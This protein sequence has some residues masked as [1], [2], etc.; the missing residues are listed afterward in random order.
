MCVLIYSLAKKPVTAPPQTST[1]RARQASDSMDIDA[2]GKTSSFNS[3]SSRLNTKS[4]KLNT[5][6]KSVRIKNDPD[7]LAPFAIDNPAGNDHVAQSAKVKVEVP[8][9]IY[10]E[11]QEE[12]NRPAPR[13]D[14]ELINLVTD[15]EDDNS[16]AVYSSRNKGKGRGLSSKGGLKPVRLQREEHKE[17]VTLVN[18]E[19]AATT[20]T[21]DANEPAD[22]QPYV[23][24]DD[25]EDDQ[26]EFS[27][28]SEKWSGVWQDDDIEVKHDP[29]T[30]DAMDVDV[31]ADPTTLT[32]SSQVSIGQVNDG[33][34]PAASASVDKEKTKRRRRPNNK[35]PVLQTEEDRA[36]YARHL[37]DLR[38]LAEELGGVQINSINENDS[39]TIDLDELTA[40]QRPVKDLE[41]RLYLF[42]LPPALPTLVNKIKKEEATDGGPDLMEVEAGPSSANEAIDLT[43]ADPEEA[44]PVETPHGTF[45]VPPEVVTEEGFVG[46]LI[47][48]KSGKVQMDWGG[49]LLELGRGVQSDYLTTTMIF[50][51]VGD[52]GPSNASAKPIGT[53]TGMGK[54]MGNFVLKPDFEA[55]GLM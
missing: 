37:E 40:E 23:S 50:E 21:D 17:R 16:D 20:L 32:K 38:I 10:P 35:Q 14:I 8:D 9:P 41:G 19:P 1:T 48:R 55:M 18:T 54:V 43:K 15:D 7:T 25:E 4:T 49:V 29:G 2:Q 45:H 31:I 12:G 13:V 34:D 3:G 33:R 22:Y 44:V 30:S 51:G 11:E 27:R 28:D 26:I 47:V 39:G 5:S 46:K 42:Q 52:G 36:E 53:G 24:T 6:P